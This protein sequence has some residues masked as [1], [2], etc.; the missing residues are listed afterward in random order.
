MTQDT[1]YLSSYSK[2]ELINLLLQEREQHANTRKHF[3]NVLNNARKLRMEQI[4]KATAL[5][6]ENNIL[7]ATVAEQN[8]IIQNNSI[9]IKN[10]ITFAK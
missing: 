9:C 4:D 3:S 1:K 8:K 10:I 6:N 7:K 5:E 2:E